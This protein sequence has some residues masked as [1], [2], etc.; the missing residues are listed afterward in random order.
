M[1]GREFVEKLR[2]RCPDTPVLF[3][4]GY[5]RS[6]NNDQEV[7]LQKPFTSQ[8]L[9]AAVKQARAPDGRLS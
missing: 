5:A 6:A 3:M 2:E 8:Q 1:S 7:Y 9:V 4:S